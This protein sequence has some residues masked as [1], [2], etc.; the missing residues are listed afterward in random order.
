MSEF[1]ERKLTQSR[2]CD[3]CHHC[4]HVDSESGYEDGDWLCLL[5][6]SE[7]D[8]DYV[9]DEI[10]ERSDGCFY[11][12]DWDWSHPEEFPDKFKQL[13][14]LEGCVDFSTCGRRVAKDN[15]CQFHEFKPG[16]ER[17]E[18]KATQSSDDKV[19]ELEERI[20][21]IEETLE[22]HEWK[23]KGTGLNVLRMAEGIHDRLKGI[24]RFLGAPMDP[25]DPEVFWKWRE[26]NTKEGKE[27]QDGQGTV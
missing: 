18:E 6:F 12:S 7:E 17:K 5:D 3:N 19:K 27:K 26:E 11:F 22:D 24:W 14:K 9:V 21:K 10:E 25:E 4:I 20:K 1:E 2:V 16:E 23:I 15:C 13:M 8:E